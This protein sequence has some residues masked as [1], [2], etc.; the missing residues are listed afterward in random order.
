MPGALLPQETPQDKY[1]GTSDGTGV[2]YWQVNIRVG[3]ILAV[4]QGGMLPNTA[5]NYF[6]SDGLASRASSLLFFSMK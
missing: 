1:L 3:D 4:L 6:M 5:R 2:H